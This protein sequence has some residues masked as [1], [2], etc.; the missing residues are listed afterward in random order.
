METFYGIAIP[1]IGTSLGAACVFF[2]KN[3]L[4]HHVERALNGFAAGVMVAASIWSLLLPA[5]EQSS[6]L[7]MLSFFPAHR[8]LD[9]HPISSGSGAQHPTSL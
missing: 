9:G 8:F 5:I 6:A 2:M 1:F 7:G 4:R 3:S